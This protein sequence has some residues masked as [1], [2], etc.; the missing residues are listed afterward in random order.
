MK[1][2]LAI[3]LCLAMV[4]SLTACGFIN[5]DEDETTPTV[6][7]NDNATQA[8]H[9]DE[10]DDPSHDHSHDHAETP[11]EKQAMW[12]QIIADG[13]L[14]TNADSLVYTVDGIMDIELLND[15]E[16]QYI[17]ISDADD[18]MGMALYK[19]GEEVYAK[20]FGIDE[21]GVLAC[22]WYVCEFPEGGEDG[23][24][25]TIMDDAE[26]TVVDT[27]SM[28][29]ML[30]NITEIKYVETI[31]GLDVLVLKCVDMSTDEDE[32]EVEFDDRAWVT[33]FDA[34]L[35]VEYN[36]VVGQFRYDIQTDNDG[37]ESW[38]AY[39]VSE[40][41]PFE[42]VS[43]WEFDS[44]DLTLTK[45]D[46]VLQC[47][48]IE[49][50]LAEVTAPEEDGVKAEEIADEMQ[51]MIDVRIKADPATYEMKEMEFEM[52][53]QTGRVEFMHC[54]NVTDLVDM[55]DEITE[56]MAADEAAMSFAMMIFAIALSAAE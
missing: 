22:E 11:D 27:E 48:L 12:E 50:H 10:C 2:L 55:P 16:N 43:D 24:E 26:S 42:Y 20:E 52:D 47:I 46:E 39:W 54:N 40:E 37:G 31:D 41:E 17:A 14:V 28:M 49:D 36:G 8:P 21:D 19:K 29:A 53:G 9:E 13:G 6:S 25:I 44:K 38:S 1:K 32:W 3:V 18:T 56:T 7:Q 45:D 51:N 5:N 30:S 4:L 33:V 35:E 34:T 15:G 23:S